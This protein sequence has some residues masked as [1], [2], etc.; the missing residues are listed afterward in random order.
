MAPKK[1][2]NHEHHIEQALVYCL[3]VLISW[4]NASRVDHMSQVCNR[5][6]TNTFRRMDVNSKYLE[7][8]QDSINVF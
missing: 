7:A 8:L 6:H 2:L 3:K 4:A 1:A 5:T